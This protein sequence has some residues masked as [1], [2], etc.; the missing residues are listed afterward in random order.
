M[1]RRALRSFRLSRDGVSSEA[2][3]AGALV[4]I[5]SDLAHGLMAEGY[6]AEIVD[7]APETQAFTAAP[8]VKRRPGRP[9][10]S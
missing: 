4:E 1:M 7:A 5:P 10:K 9:R 6:I 3:A 8:E 2:V